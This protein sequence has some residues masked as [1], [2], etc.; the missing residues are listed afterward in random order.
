M[1][2]GATS[3]ERAA[4]AGDHWPGVAGRARNL[5]ARRGAEAAGAADPWP[6]I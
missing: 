1:A 3:R 6:L 4:A 2:E 5:F